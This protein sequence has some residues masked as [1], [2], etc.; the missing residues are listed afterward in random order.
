MKKSKL[1]KLIR[2]V[3]TEQ[4][5]NQPDY[6]PPACWDPCATNSISQY[7]AGL[8]Q[9][10]YV[11]PWLT[12]NQVWIQ[13]EYG[14]CS[15]QPIEMSPDYATYNPESIEDWI[16]WMNATLPNMN[17]GM[18]FLNN[19]CG[20]GVEGYSTDMVPGGNGPMFSN[21]ILDTDVNISCC[22]Y[23]EGYGEEEPTEVACYTC[24]GGSEVVGKKFKL[25]V[26][27]K[28]TGC[29]QGWSEDYESVQAGCGGT[30]QGTPEV[31]S[32]GA[33]K[34]ATKAQA[35]KTPTRKR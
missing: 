9:G 33:Q 6:G 21:Y 20:Y 15:G 28:V 34:P 7:Q 8:Q 24:K 3:I 22:T 10:N 12:P 27:S 26:N 23:P 32:K 16:H 14:D 1:R 29:P 13:T 17:Q 19:F 18:T 11:L 30:I 2:E 25:G 35:E 31:P 4:G 5:W